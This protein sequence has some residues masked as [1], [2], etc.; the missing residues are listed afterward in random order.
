MAH[1]LKATKKDIPDCPL[2]PS[3]PPD[4]HM[5]ELAKDS[6]IQTSVKLRTKRGT[7]CSWEVVTVMDA[8]GKNFTFHGFIFW[9][10]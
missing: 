10:S 5:T 9:S 3:C 7:C 6:R 4:R 1:S 2:S 8:S